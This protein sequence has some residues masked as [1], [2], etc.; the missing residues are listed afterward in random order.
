MTHDVLRGGRGDELAAAVHRGLDSRWVFISLPR[1]MSTSTL[2]RSVRV[3]HRVQ[4][5]DHRVDVGG[6]VIRGATACSS[7]YTTATADSFCML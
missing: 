1:S 6:G 7:T 5:H 3:T 2:S 4:V